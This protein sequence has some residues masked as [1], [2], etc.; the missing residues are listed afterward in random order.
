M[1]ARSAFTLLVGAGLGAAVMYMLDPRTGARRRALARDKAV[2]GLK[3]A[4]R[5]SNR[6]VRNSFNRAAGMTAEIRSYLRLHSRSV[7]DA[8]LADRVRS[9]LGHVV[10]HP[11]LLD[12]S[13]QGGVVTVS[14]PVLQGEPSRIAGRM[15]KIRGVKSY[16]LRVEAH[17]TPEHM[18]GL[19]GESHPEEQQER[20]A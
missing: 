8:A 2:H 13:A 14:G 11:G 10:A 9:H 4:G 5:W 16:E 17:A 18:P 19:Q 12:V 15:R 6:K 1:K 3:L 7:N 20:A